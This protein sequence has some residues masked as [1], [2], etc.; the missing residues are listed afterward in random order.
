MT[1]TDQGHLQQKNSIQYYFHLIQ[2]KRVSKPQSI[3]SEK[4]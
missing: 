1:K 3:S 2:D 4:V